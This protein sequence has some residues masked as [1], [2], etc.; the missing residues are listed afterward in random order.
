MLW[1]QLPCQEERPSQAEGIFVL[2]L[3]FSDL[4]TAQRCL[5]KFYYRHV[6]R[7]QS[8][9]KNVTL[10]EGTAIHRMLM[11]GF[12]SIQNG[13]HWSLGVAEESARLLKEAATWAFADE[14]ADAEEMVKKDA[15]IVTGYFERNPFE[16]WT[17]LHVEEE[18]QVEIDGETVTFTPDLVVRDPEGH[19]WIIDHKST[20]S[21]PEDGPPF[22]SQQSLLYFAGVRAFYPEAVGFLFNYLRKKLPTQ[23]R[24]NKNRTKD[25]G[26]YHINNLKA[27][28]TTF[29]L[30]YEFIKTEAPELLDEP[31]HKM[32]LAELRDAPDRWYYTKRVLANDHALSRIV[33]ESSW[34]VKQINDAIEHNRFPRTLNEDRG[35][36]SCGKCE[37]EPI[38]RAELLDLNTD[39]VL[40]DYEPRDE[41]NPYEGDDDD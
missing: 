12:L 9:H 7:L 28:D 25:T 5:L 35:Y 19:V 1:P 33:E 36:L 13:E 3:S 17:I 23:P 6:R 4:N 40:M 14:M 30:L 24:L 34:I 37:F 20:S 10:T 27:I 26:L 11:A 22:A 38:C 21:I 29:E 39:V 31:S 15:W 32:R 41:K 2:S 8:K 18:F 16:G